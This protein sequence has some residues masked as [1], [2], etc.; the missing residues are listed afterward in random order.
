MHHFVNGGGGAYLDLQMG[1][2]VPPK[3]ASP[4]EPAEWI[5]PMEK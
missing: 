4:E 3:G 2:A 5:V 1:G